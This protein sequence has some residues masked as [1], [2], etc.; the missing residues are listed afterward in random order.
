MNNFRFL[1]FYLFISFI[2]FCSLL[3][4]SSCFS[5]SPSKIELIHAN[6]LEGD[7]RFGKDVRR[8][9]GN[10][11][12]RQDSAYM[13]CDSAYLFAATNSLDAYGHVR[14][15]QGDTI[16]LTGDMLK[17]DGNAKLARLFNNITLADRKM[18]LTTNTMLYNM[19]TGI[20]DY[21]DGGKIVDAENILTSTIGNY[22]SKEK[23]F[24][25]HKNVVLLHPGY[26]METD[27]LVYFSLTK[28]SY[29][30]GPCYIRSTDSSFIYCETGW[31]NTVT[32]KSYFGKKAYLQNKEQQ[33]FGDS[34]LYDSKTKVG[35]AFYNV[36]VIDTAEKIIVDGDYAFYDELK[37]K[38]FVTGKTMMT[39]AFEKDSLF[40]HGDTLFATYDS[41]TKNKSYFAYH[42]VRLYKTDLQGVCDSLVYNSADSMLH[43]F[44]NPVLWSDKNQ[45]AADS[46]SMQISNNKI[47][48]MYLVSNAFIASK[49]DSVRYNQVRG[50]TMTGFFS[51]NSLY[52]MDVFGNG[53]S[54]Y[55]ARNKKNQLTGVNRSECSSMI[56]L[57]TNNK[58]SRIKLIEKPDAT[59]YPI[60]ELAPS[61]LLLKGFSWQAKRRPVS[62]EDIF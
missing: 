10:V 47:D 42:K 11:V 52:R 38:S 41:I 19:N 8:L 56:I 53:Q 30:Y 37:G 51:D 46:I 9:L 14:I 22:F 5:Q 18:V 21:V 26:K 45:L 17:Y 44:T 4:S 36:Q 49:E 20:A 7:E 54:I 33:L 12:F 28:T 57:F 2:S 16:T 40:M 50:K 43:L 25:F 6:T 39:K 32:E 29:F 3:V 34:I 13:Y 48:K 15:Q 24:T 60:G 1:F 61:E 35:R 62:K 58:V 59:F 23:K 55:Y 27:T 31:Y